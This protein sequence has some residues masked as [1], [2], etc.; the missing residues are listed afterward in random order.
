MLW[1]KV[2]LWP[3]GD[4]SQK[5]Q[6]GIMRITNDGT[7]TK[8]HGNYEVTLSACP[9]PEQIRKG[10]CGPEWTLEWQVGIVRHLKGFPRKRKG[11]FELVQAA[12]NNFFNEKGKT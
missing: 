5:Q 1:V 6:I 11:C 10:T 4:E 2:E 7:G 12:L 8:A 9:T 3:G